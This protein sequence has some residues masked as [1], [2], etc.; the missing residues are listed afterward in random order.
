MQEGYGTANSPLYDDIL[1]ADAIP[2]PEF[3]KSRGNYVPRVQSIPFSVYLDPDYAKLEI[4]NVWKRSWQFACREEDIPEIGDCLPYDVGPLSFIIV[5]SGKD[6]FRAFYNSCLHKGTRLCDAH[7]NVKAIRCRFHGWQ[8]NLDGAL[9]HV[10]ALWD[11]P[12]VD[13]TYRLPQAAIDRWGGCLFI[14][15]D[16]RC[17]PLRDALGVMQDHFRN[18]DLAQRF[19]VL[20]TRKKIR[21]NWKVVFEGFLESYHV[22]QTHNQITNFTGDVNSRY[23]IFDDGKAKIGRFMAPIGVSSPLRTDGATPREAAITLMQQFIATLGGGNAVLPDFDAIPDFGRKDVAAWRRNMIKT[24]FGADV[25]HLSDAEMLDGIQYHMFPNFAPWLGEGF[26]VMYQFLPYGTDPNHSVFSVRLLM[27]LASGA[28]RPPAAKP[29]EMDFDDP[30][31]SVPEWGA[32]CAVYDQDVATLPFVQRGMQSAADGHTSS[33]L[34]RYQE[35][36]CSALY[37]FVEEKIRGS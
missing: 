27:P 35:Q 17:G 24:T 12:T 30:Y 23:D 11:F 32:M 14:N 28:A 4:Q 9:R 34:A 29:I 2:P 19:T 8:W 3:M 37:E 6:T 15:P 26:S 36:R 13:E 1:A 7:I 20:H 18:F 10:P 31:S 25:A 5:R 22:W 16:P 33:T 21:A